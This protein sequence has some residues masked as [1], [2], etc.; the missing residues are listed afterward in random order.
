MWHGFDFK[1][2]PLCK[3]QTPG[4]SCWLWVKFVHTVWKIEEK[5]PVLKYFTVVPKGMLCE[6]G[7]EEV[8]RRWHRFG[9][10]R[11]CGQL[12]SHVFWV[13]PSLGEERGHEEVG[14]EPYWQ[15]CACR[16]AVTRLVPLFQVTHR[17]NHPA[18]QKKRITNRVCQVHGQHLATSRQTMRS[19][20]PSSVGC[21]YAG[22]LRGK[23]GD[24]E[25]PQI[26]DNANLPSIFR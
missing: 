18:P 23:V 6:P 5:F 24:D 11:S 3:L 19:C 15:K 8:K 13:T 2:T 22:C 9:Y 17:P 16:G 14:T 20:P 26:N 10:P 4:F 1:N 7:H 21:T 12:E 25:F